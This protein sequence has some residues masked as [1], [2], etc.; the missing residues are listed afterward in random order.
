MN[1]GHQLCLHLY[2]EKSLDSECLGLVYVDSGLSFDEKNSVL[3]SNFN[4][5]IK[6][7]KGEIFKGWENDTKHSGT[8]GGTVSGWE[9][10]AR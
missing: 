4:V 9:T 2:Q 10:S 6:K 3:G 1:Q 5:M 7:S 8:D